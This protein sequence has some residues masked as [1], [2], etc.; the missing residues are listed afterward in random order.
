VE[1]QEVS[2]EKYGTEPAG[3]YAFFPENGNQ[4]F[5]ARIFFL[6]KSKAITVTGN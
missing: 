6:C 2:W 3:S 1:T 4:K 5:G